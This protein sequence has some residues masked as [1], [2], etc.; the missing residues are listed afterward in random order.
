MVYASSELTLTRI[1][2]S[3]NARINAGRGVKSTSKLGREENFQSIL[4]WFG[5]NGFMI[6]GM[7]RSG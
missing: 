2:L 5:K 7:I 6:I 1:S 4:K 3:R